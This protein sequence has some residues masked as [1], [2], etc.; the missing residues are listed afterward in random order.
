MGRGVGERVG[1]AVG[2]AVGDGSSVGVKVTVGNGVGG[3][4]C[5]GD[6]DT[7]TEVAPAVVLATA[8]GATAVGATAVSAAQLAKKSAIIQAAKERYCIRCTA[9]AGSR[10]SIPFSSKRSIIGAKIGVVST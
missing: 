5:E 4:V 9:Q 8:A 1:E 10:N 7:A 3:G 2:A 6:G